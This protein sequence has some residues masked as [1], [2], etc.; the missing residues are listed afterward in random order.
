MDCGDY[1]YKLCGIHEPNVCSHKQIFPITF[2][3]V[4]GLITFA[5]FMALSNIAGIGGGGVAVPLL[6]G[7]FHLD[8]KEAIAVSSLNIAITTL[9]RFILNFHR[10]HPEKPNVSVIDYNI[11]TIMMPTCMAGAQIGAFILITFPDLYIVIA[12]TFTVAA[13]C[14]E[15]YNRALIITEQEEKKKLEDVNKSLFDKPIERLDSNVTE[16][17]PLMSLKSASP[18][19]VFEMTSIQRSSYETEDNQEPTDAEVPQ[20]VAKPTQMIEISGHTFPLGVSEEQD[21]ALHKLK[22]LVYAQRT[23]F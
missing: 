22:A 20:A 16:S 5:A 3:E 12:L 7:F 18:Q 6:I 1:P 14:K 10:K 17:D 21:F 15:T 8:T 4:I 2:L 9:T 19:T 23:H 13:L 11:L